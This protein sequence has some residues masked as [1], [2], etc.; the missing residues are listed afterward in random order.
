MGQQ[1]LYCRNL[2]LILV[3][4][5][6]YPFMASTSSLSAQPNKQALSF[7]DARQWRTHSVSLS[8]DGAWYTKRYSLYDDPDS[9]QDTTSPSP[10]EDFFTEEHQTDVLYICSSEDGIIHRVPDG[11]KPKFS[12]ASD[13]IA[14]QIKPKPDK[15]KEEKEKESEE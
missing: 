13:W 1:S 4:I 5:F 12:P 9:D 3:S 15:K 14:Y 8:D 6:S 7:D 10:F 11:Q 2:L